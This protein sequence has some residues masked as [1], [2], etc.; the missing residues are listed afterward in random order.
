VSAS[1]ELPVPYEQ[2]T[3]CLKYIHEWREHL[4]HAWAGQIKGAANVQAAGEA[5][6][7]LISLALLIEKARQ[8]SPGSVAS[9]RDVITSLETPSV[10]DLWTAVSQSASSPLLAAVFDGDGSGTQGP[11]PDKALR[12]STLH[13]DRYYRNR[14]E[15]KTM[16]RLVFG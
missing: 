4:A 2:V 15:S 6:D 1:R 11:V 10:Y 5:V 7:D 13:Q 12:P 16:P 9:L 8:V 14:P 3:R